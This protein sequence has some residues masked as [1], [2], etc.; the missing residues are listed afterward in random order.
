MT[1]QDL[2]AFCI[3]KAIQVAEMT[4]ELDIKKILAI[5]ETIRKFI[6]KENNKEEKA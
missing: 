4:R 5:A 3:N 1:K 2:G 6:E